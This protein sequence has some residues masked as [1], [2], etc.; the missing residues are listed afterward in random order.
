MGILIRRRRISRTIPD[1]RRLPYSRALESER[2]SPLCLR[3]CRVKK[4]ENGLPIRRNGNL[5]CCAAKAADRSDGY[6][7]P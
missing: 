4:H 3:R 7:T 2:D 5:R 1:A 6:K